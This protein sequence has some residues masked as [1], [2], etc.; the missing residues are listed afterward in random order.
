MS[1]HADVKRLAQAIVIIGKI[2]S[3]VLEP[4]SRMTEDGER[5]SGELKTTLELL[6]S[7][8][9]E[10]VPEINGKSYLS[11]HISFNMRIDYH[12]ILFSDLPDI[13]N[14][15]EEWAKSLPR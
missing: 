10:I 3:A 2:R 11:R 9:F 12:D 5:G 15:L 1:D 4:W 7:R 14:A 8:L 6:A 13:E